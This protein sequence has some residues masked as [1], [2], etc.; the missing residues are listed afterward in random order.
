MSSDLRQIGTVTR[1]HGLRGE[2][3]VRPETDDPSRFESLDHVMLG[4]SEADATPYRVTGVRYQPMQS[5][6]AVVLSLE[7]LASRESAEEVSGLAVWAEED[8]LPPLEDDEVFV[9]DLVGLEVHDSDGRRAGVVSDVLDLP[10]QCILVV[11]RDA[12]GDALVPFVPGL[13]ESVDESRIVVRDVE[14]L[15]DPDGQEEAA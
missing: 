10:A 6:V 8:A 12:G 15:L 5:G 1:P 11:R 13:I 9:S 7:G 14:G 3:K 2:V 4:E